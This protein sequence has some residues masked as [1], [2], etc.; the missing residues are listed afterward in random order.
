[1]RGAKRPKPCEEVARR[2]RRRRHNVAWYGGGR[3]Y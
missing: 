2:K 1:V 3:E